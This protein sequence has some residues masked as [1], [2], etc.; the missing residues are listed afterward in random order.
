MNALQKKLHTKKAWHFY[1]FIGFPRSWTTLSTQLQRIKPTP[2][3]G[4][5][6]ASFWVDS[7]SVQVSGNPEQAISLFPI[8]WCA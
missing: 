8:L 7:E 4:S 1:V 6:V 3:G 5:A 2:F